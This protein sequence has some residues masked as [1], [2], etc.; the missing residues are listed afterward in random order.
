M[1]EQ[2]F[3]LLYD[4]HRGL[5]RSAHSRDTIDDA[6]TIIQN[7]SYADT[8][9]AGERSAAENLIYVL[10]KRMIS[11]TQWRN[12]PTNYYKADIYNRMNTRNPSQGAFDGAFDVMANGTG[13]GKAAKDNKVNYQSI[14]V[15]IPRLQRW[16]EFAKRL[17]KTL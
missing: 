15:L 17:H 4:F 3:N 5:I 11:L 13:I 9:R 16:D 1:K 14:K 7:P 10:E 2:Q 12:A 6:K 8:L